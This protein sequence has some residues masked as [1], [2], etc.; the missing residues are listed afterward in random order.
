MQDIAL[1]A[2]PRVSGGEENDLTS[3]ASRKASWGDLGDLEDL[4]FES[5]S[6]LEDLE[7]DL[8]PSPI[9]NDLQLEKPEF[10][11]NEA[12]AI[13]MPTDGGGSAHDYSGNSPIHL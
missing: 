4:M 10:A 1:F 5:D 3:L 13:D 11:S 6:Q 7:E 2:L 9:E 8:V 12:P